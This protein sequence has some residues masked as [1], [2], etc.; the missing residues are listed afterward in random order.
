MSKF[1]IKNC[2]DLE[3]TYELKAVD[4]L[5]HE[6]SVFLEAIASSE[7]TT[8]D[9]ILIPLLTVV[10]QAMKNADMH[11][12][13]S[14][15]QGMVLFTV[16][17][18]EVGTGKSKSQKAVRRAWKEVNDLL[19]IPTDMRRILSGKMVNKYSSDFVI[20]LCFSKY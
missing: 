18:G 9:S 15:K 20:Y 19:N 8:V 3:F 6:L 5:D 14:F 17:I 2:P 13:R 12:L 11:A 1:K 4:C 16:L 7:S 10:S